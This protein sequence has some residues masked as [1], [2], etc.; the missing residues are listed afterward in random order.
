[1]TLSAPVRP[2]ISQIVW[3]TSQTSRFQ[4]MA[5]GTNESRQDIILRRSE[6][7]VRLTLIE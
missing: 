1:M 5:D 7:L 4:S 2:L 3:L 6:L